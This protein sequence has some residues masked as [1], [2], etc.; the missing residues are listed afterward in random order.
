MLSFSL[1]QVLSDLQ[2]GL[3]FA[4]TLASGQSG[5]GSVTMHDGSKISSAL[6]GWDQMVSFST[7]IY[8]TCRA[9]LL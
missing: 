8:S 7:E 5:R 2:A 4:R 3:A 1:D 6:S 9:W